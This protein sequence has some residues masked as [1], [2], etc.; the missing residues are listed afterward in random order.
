MLGK[1]VHEMVSLWRRFDTELPEEGAG[2]ATSLWL[3]LVALL[4][5]TW[6]VGAPQELHAGEALFLLQCPSSALY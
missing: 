4:C 6:G 3:F 1:T 2:E 5:R